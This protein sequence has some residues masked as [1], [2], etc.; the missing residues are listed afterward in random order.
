MFL[1]GLCYKGEVEVN[2][3]GVWEKGH[4]EPLW[5]ITDLSP[6][7]DCKR[8]A[9]EESFRDLKNLLGLK[10]LM[11]KIQEYLEVMV[12]LVLTAYGI[13]L[14]L[15]EVMREMVFCGSKSYRLY[16]G[17]FV[18]L[19]LKVKVGHEDVCEIVERALFPCSLPPPVSI[20][21][22]SSVTDA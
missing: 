15:G 2:V 5:V 6:S 17:L 9:I 8:I 16:S 20:H 1:E 19:R 10:R 14:V 13:G 22:W 4:P 7:T 21:V 3:A 18:L 11:N 12:A